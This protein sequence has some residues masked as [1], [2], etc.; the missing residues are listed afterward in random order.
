MKAA[1]DFEQP[2]GLQHSTAGPWPQPALV[3]LSADADPWPAAVVGLNGSGKALCITGSGDLLA[4]DARRVTIYPT[5][6][7]D[8]ALD[9]AIAEYR[10][11][12][13]RRQVA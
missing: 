11:Y 12:L 1:G 4:I 2:G 7:L 6:A 8:R 3:W 5:G 10:R 9:R 13:N